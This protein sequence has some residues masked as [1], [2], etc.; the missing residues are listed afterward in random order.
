MFKVLVLYDQ[1]DDPAAFDK[2][3]AETHTPLVRKIPNLQTIQLNRVQGNAMGGDSPYYLI[4]ELHF[5]DK[6]AFE[7]A[8]ASEAFKATGADLA[9]FAKGK[10]TILLA[11]SQG[12]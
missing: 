7:Q 4:A 5:S 12:A 6:A 1:P 10:V 2:Y 8:A 11:D 3:Y 9:N